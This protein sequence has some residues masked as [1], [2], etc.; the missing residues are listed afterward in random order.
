LKNNFLHPRN[1]SKEGTEHLFVD[2]EGKRKQEIYPDFISKDRAIIADAKYKHLEY[3]N[4]EY[5][6]NDYFQIITYMYRFRT[7]QG[8]LLFP[9]SHKT[10]FELYTIKDTEGKL[11]KLGL[12][13]PQQ[14]NNFN[15]FSKQI[16]E[17]EEEFVSSLKYQ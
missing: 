5:G 4:E 9:H 10:F 13:I 2:A 16:N 11:T 12:A 1:K 17:K 6:R 7:K 3:S 8:F 14:A 15:I